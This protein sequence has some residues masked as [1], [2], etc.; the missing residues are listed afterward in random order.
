MVLPLSRLHD[1]REELEALWGNAPMCRKRGIDN[2]N[3]QE[4]KVFSKM[5]FPVY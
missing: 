4:F 5:D 2:S 3:E 1:A